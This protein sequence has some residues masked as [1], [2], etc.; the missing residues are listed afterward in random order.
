MQAHFT[1]TGAFARAHFMTNIIAPGLLN[2]ENEGPM[3]PPN[4]GNYLPV[5]KA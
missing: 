1:Q 2:A 4:S 3:I 5:D